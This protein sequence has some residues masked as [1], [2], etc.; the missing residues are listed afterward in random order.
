MS[1]YVDNA[2][3]GDWQHAGTDSA[4]KEDGVVTPY[5]NNILQ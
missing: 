3:D 1:F 4:A 2:D 5:G